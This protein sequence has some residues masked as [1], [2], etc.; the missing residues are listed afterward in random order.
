M[1]KTWMLIKGYAVMLV[2][3]LVENAAIIVVST[4]VVLLIVA[5]SIACYRCW[6]RKVENEV[7]ETSRRLRE[8]GGINDRYRKVFNVLVREEVHKKELKSKAQFDRFKPEKQLPPIIE[9]DPQYYL[10]W[11]ELA[12]ENAGSWSSYCEAVSKISSTQ[13]DRRSRIRAEER[14]FK[15][16]TLKEPVLE[17]RIIVEWHYISP[18]GR[19]TYYDRRCFGSKSIRKAIDTLGSKTE[20]QRQIEKERALMTPKLRYDVMKR[21]G[22]KCALCGSSVDDGVQLH[23]DHIFP[24]SKGGKTELS[25]LRTLCD[26]CNMGKGARIERAPNRCDENQERDVAEPCFAG[27]HAMQ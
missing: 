27:K 2:N 16:T 22:F 6:V 19:N 24:V 23:V 3:F 13:Y 8:L 18:K 4:L 7:H 15:K 26:R 9:S 1:S 12:E 21:D 20:R 5:A 25:N 11:V 10:S 17:P 14:L